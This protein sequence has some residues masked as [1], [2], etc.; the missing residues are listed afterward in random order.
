MEEED[1]AFFNTIDPV[2]YFFRCQIE[3]FTHAII[4]D[5][6]PRPRERMD[7]RR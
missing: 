3:S 2:A 6:A 4:E 5:T 7:E 1:T